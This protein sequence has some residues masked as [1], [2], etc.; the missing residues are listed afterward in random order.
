MIWLIGLLFFIAGLGIALYYLAPGLMFALV[1]RLAR[2]R[3]RLVLREVEVDR[4]RLPYLEGG[5]GEPL[6]L[7]HGFASNKDHWTMIAPHLTRHFHV[8]A[9]DLPGF[10]DASRL[11]E[12]GY[13]LDAQL[14]RVAQF[15]DAVGLDSF[16]LG[17][18]SMGGY[19]ATMFAVRYPERVRSL[20]LLAPAGVMSAEP[21]ET[22]RL[23]EAGEN[24]F[25]ADTAAAFDRLANLCFTVQPPMPAEFK[26]PLLARAR[27]EA[28]FNAKI[29]AEIFADPL[30]LE[31]GAAGLATRT[32]LVW[33]DDDRILH[34]SGLNI[35]AGLLPQAERRLMP[36][37]GHV[38]M[39]ERPAETA[40]DWLRFHRITP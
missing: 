35:L 1:M 30:A 17:G 12:A 18:N 19:L 22:L 23:I 9:P 26:R 34:P 11:E 39:I 14:A 21:S 31:D 29:F 8:Y 28:P 36:R 5:S 2:W 6:L 37:M 7:L 20:W 10:G 33:G 27:A 16:H 15:A 25:I 38:P 3:G 4:H 40:A 32:L 24:P 13:G